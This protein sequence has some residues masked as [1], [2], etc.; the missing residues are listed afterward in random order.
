MS[1]HI[2]VVLTDEQR[3]QLQS[4]VRTGSSPARTLTRAR[5]LL[6]LDGGERK[7]RNDETIASALLCHKSTVGNV[8]RRFVASGL[9]A[10]LYDK[11]RPGAKPKITGEVEAH[12]TTLACSNPPEGQARWT[13][14]LLAG[15][16]VELGHVE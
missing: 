9:D 11:P 5:I 7:A 15:R 6:L 12:L 1:K 4:L 2:P 8:R 16:L 3:Q 14:R 10:A 13:L